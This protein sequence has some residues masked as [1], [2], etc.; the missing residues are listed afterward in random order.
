MWKVVSEQSVPLRAVV[1]G[2]KEGGGEGAAEDLPVE[3]FEKR[4]ERQVWLSCLAVESRWFRVRREREDRSAGDEAAVVTEQEVFEETRR[5]KEM[6]ALRR[7]L[8]GGGVGREGK[9]AL[10]PE[11]DDVQPVVLEEPEGALAA[12]AY[13]A[14]YGEGEFCFLG[15]LGDWLVG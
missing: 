7:E 3:A 12:I 8:Y 14:D 9:L 13:P 15:W 10:D 2:T 5:R 4:W 11:W 1:V 6:A